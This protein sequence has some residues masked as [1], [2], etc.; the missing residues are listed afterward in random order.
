MRRGLI[1]VRSKF[2]SVVVTIRDLGFRYHGY[3]LLTL[4]LLG[5]VVVTAVNYTTSIRLYETFMLFIGWNQAVITGYLSFKIYT[6]SKRDSELPRLVFEL[7]DVEEIESPWK[8]HLTVNCTMEIV[9]M[10]H[11]RAKIKNVGLYTN[12]DESGLEMREVIGEKQISGEFPIGK[13]TPVILDNGEKC[14]IHFQVNGFPYLDDL[15][16]VVNESQIGKMEYNITRTEISNEVTFK[17]Q[18]KRSK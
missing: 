7:T 8:R 11:G 2:T 3:I 1:S 5:T 9:N 17:Q 18:G 13:P 10:S 4:L 16:I 14:Q 12:F 15:R 6:V